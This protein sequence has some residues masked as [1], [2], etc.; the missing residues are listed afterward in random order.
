[1]AARVSTVVCAR[2]GSGVALMVWKFAEAAGLFEGRG[3]R[4]VV[5]AQALHLDAEGAL[6]LEEFG[7]LFSCEK[8]GGYAVF[9]GAAGAAYAVDEVLGNLG[10]V[11]IDDLRDVLDVDAARGDVGGDQD[12]VAPLLESSE[13]GVPLGLR[14][15]AVNH[16]GGEA[17]AI[18][19]FA[20]TIGGAFGAGEHEAATGFL[21][22]Q[23]VER[24][25]LP[26][27]GNLESLHANILRGLQNGT[28]RK[29]HGIP[30]VVLHEMHDGGFQCCRET[31]GLAFFRQNRGNSANG[32]EKAHVEH[33]VSFV[34]NEDAKILEVEKPA[35]QEILEPAGSGDDEARALANGAKLCAFGE[36][37]DYA[38]R[39]LKLSAAEQVVLLDDL[40]GEFAGR[41]E[42]QRGDPGRIALEQ[43]LH[44]GDQKRQRFAGSGLRRGENI[45]ALERLRDSGGLHRSGCRELCSRQT[46]LGVGGNH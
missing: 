10:Q 21:G 13:G 31:H 27:G 38:C 29:A 28:E 6:E 45:L 17:V 44:H 35:V 14:A 37:A 39:W 40:H 15:V 1:V 41:N 34:E 4:T 20:D 9:S 46:L 33:A 7:A 43:A 16:G 24:L 25:L 22:K 19:I 18:E 2:G 8:R 11:E 32:W 26:I 5:G 30:H 36:S 42:D 23:A 12:A 3:W